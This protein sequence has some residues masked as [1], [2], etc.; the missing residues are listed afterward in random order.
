MH[1]SQNGLSAAMATVVLYNNNNNT[2]G[3]HIKWQHCSPS[4]HI[5][6]LPRPFRAC[7]ICIWRRAAAANLLAELETTAE[8]VC[9]FIRRWWWFM[10]HIEGAHGWTA[11]APTALS[12]ANCANILCFFL[13]YS[14]VSFSLTF[15]EGWPSWINGP[16]WEVAV[17]AQSWCSTTRAKPTVWLQRDAN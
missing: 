5:V 1:I 6:C 10:G 7:I 3:T 8:F 12:T 16:G 2:G 4:H 11:H 14:R 15:D 17:V 9:L 13:L